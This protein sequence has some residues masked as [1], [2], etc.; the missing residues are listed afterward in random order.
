[1]DVIDTPGGFELAGTKTDR[2]RA[3]DVESVLGDAPTH[4]FS[5][6]WV[7][8]GWADDVVR[9]IGALG[10]HGGEGRVQHVVV[11]AANSDAEWPE[12][13]EVIELDRDPGWATARNA[14]LK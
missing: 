8:Q 5:V 11:D 14:G 6:H 7:V 2:V 4:E 3:E 12:Q 9:G 10:R 13:A 1:Y